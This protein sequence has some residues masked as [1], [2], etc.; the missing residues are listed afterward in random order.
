MFHPPFSDSVAHINAHTSKLAL[1]IK[2]RDDWMQNTSCGLKPSKSL[3]ILH[4]LLKKLTGLEEG[5]Y[6]IVHKAGEPF[7][8]IF[9]AADG[10][11]SRG[12]YN[13][14]QVHSSVPQPPA[15][16]LMPWIPVNPAMVLPFHRKHNRVP[17][18]FPPKPFLKTTQDGTPQSYHPGARQKNNFNAQGNAG[19]NQTKRTARR[20]KY[21]KKLIQKSV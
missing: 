3:N 10:K 1:R 5:Q 20:K 16:G 11:V 18:T 12:A 14:Q 17:C 13:L 19:H 8:T 7:V 15:S 21:M 2:M 4:H 6:L 9:K